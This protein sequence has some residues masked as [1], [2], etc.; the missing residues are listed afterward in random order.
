MKISDLVEEFTL[1]KHAKYPRIFGDSQSKIQHLVLEGYK[2]RALDLLD[3][4]EQKEYQERIIHELNVMKK[5]DAIDYMLLEQHI[6]EEMRK[7]DRYPGAGRG[8]VAG[9]LVAYLLR[10]TDVDPI[11]EN[12]LFSRFIN[13]DRISMQD[14]DSDWYEDDR[15]RVQEFLLTHNKLHCASIV[16]YGTLGVKSAFKEVARGLGFPYDEINKASKEF[17]EDDGVTIITEI[18]KNAHQEVCQ[19]AEEVGGVVTNVGRHAAGVI[20][21]DRDLQSEIGTI[22]VK[23]FKY[24]V[25]MI[26]MSG[27]ESLQYVKLDVLGLKNIGWIHRATE[28]AGIERIAPDVDYADFNDWAVAESIAKDNSAIFQFESDRTGK[29]VKEIFSE[30]SL[31]RIK[32]FNPN[33]TVV[34]L[35]SVATAVSD[36][37]QYQLSKMYCKASQNIMDMKH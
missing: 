20:V 26:D 32:E 21:S 34:E 7:E 37:V 36:Q 14:V 35:L 17:I 3:K 2:D 16:T 15:E 13:P 29:V 28:L 18:I 8:S 23:D 27:V 5:V 9:S 1:D 33:I 25:S 31:K 24:P 22:E 30:T 12:L 6:K 19:I 4:S 10:I 11:K